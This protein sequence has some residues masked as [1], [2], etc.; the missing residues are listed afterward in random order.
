MQLVTYREELSELF[1][2]KREIAPP[3][4]FDEDIPVKWQD[5]IVCTVP[6][7]RVLRAVLIH[8]LSSS[9]VQSAIS[10]LETNSELCFLTHSVKEELEEVKESWILPVRPEER[11]QER[12]SIE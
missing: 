6:N 8:D 9:V 10:S 12:I 2:P 3:F 1:P 4:V 5:F 11:I 7:L